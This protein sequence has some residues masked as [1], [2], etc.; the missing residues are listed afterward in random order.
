MAQGD[1]MNGCTT[2]ITFDDITRFTCG[3]CYQLAQAINEITGWPIYAFWDEHFE[4]YDIHAFVKTPRGTFMDITGE[5]SRYRMFRRWE[6][7][8]HIR[9]VSASYDMR[10]WDNGNPFYDSLPRAREVAPVLIANYHGEVMAR[11]SDYNSQR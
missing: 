10:Q 6:W 7:A 4:D 8:A 9:K 1:L 11:V 2:Q 3:S 5:H